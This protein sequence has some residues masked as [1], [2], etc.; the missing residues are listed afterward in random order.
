MNLLSAEEESLYN[1]VYV[2][3]LSFAFHILSLTRHE[4][5]ASC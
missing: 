4:D 1:T 5:L 2:E 3:L